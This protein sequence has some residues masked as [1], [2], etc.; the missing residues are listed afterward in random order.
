MN[1][2]ISSALNDRRAPE[3]DLISKQ[4]LLFSKSNMSKTVQDRATVTIERK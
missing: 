1:G 2:V 4:L 3:P